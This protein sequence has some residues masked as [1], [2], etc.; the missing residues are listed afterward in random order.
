MNIQIE[1]ILNNLDVNRD[2]TSLYS[3]VISKESN[4]YQILIID[5]DASHR[6]L[7]SE[8][9]VSTVYDLS[10]AA[11]RQEAIALLMHQEFDLILLDLYLEDSHGVDLC[12]DIR[13]TLNI[14]TPIIIISGASSDKELADCL[15]H[16]AN[17][18]IKKPYSPVELIARTE[19]AIKNKRLI[20][21]LDTTE[22][23]FFSVARMVEAR[24]ENT[25]E[26]C[27]RLSYYAVVFGNELGLSHTELLALKRGAILH[28]IGKLGVPDYIL[29]KKGPLNDQE[30]EIMKRHTVIGAR[31]CEGMR[32]MRV[33]LPII[34]HHHERFDGSGYPDGLVG[35][36][37]PYLARVFQII[38]IYDALSS[39]RPY[40]ERWAL[41]RVVETLNK[42]KREGRLDPVLT[43]K[44]LRLIANKPHVLTTRAAMQ[45]VTEMGN[46]GL[47]KKP[48]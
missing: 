16:G 36:N 4:P 42:E 44:F 37:I 47:L 48:A 6:N 27:S 39:Q 25:G 11:N 8:I 23:L 41:P 19:V 38:D 28:D 24:D 10:M 13:N 29:L 2:S 26:H 35:E 33:T 32:S 9:L 5:D 31:L 40:K 1:N 3:S 17:D 34:R 15:G 22:S 18:F 46:V 21:Q 43:D 12:E 20:E 30:F 14:F 45:D 7:V